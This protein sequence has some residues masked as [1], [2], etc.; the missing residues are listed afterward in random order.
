MLR[1]SPGHPVKVDPDAL[2][3]PLSSGGPQASAQWLGAAVTAGA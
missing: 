1:G 3:A 2:T